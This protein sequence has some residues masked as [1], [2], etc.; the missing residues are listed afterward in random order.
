MPFRDTIEDYRRSALRRLED[1]RELL[2]PPTFDPQ[3][4]PMQTGTTCAVRC[5]C[6]DMR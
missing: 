4:D 1:A 3:N 6:L 5:I 2:E